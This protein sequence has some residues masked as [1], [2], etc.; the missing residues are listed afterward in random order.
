MTV[1]SQSTLDAVRA[2]PSDTA[3]SPANETRSPSEG[4][5]PA[6]RSSGSATELSEGMSIGRYTVLSRLGVG[7]MGVVV[8]AYDPELDRKVALKLL[9]SYGDDRAAAQGRL[10]REAQALARLSHPNVVAV[11]DVGVHEG[12]VFLAMEFIAGQTLGRWMTHGPAGDPRPWPEVLRVFEAAG[13]GLAAAHDVGLVHRDF[14]PENVMLGD[15]GR[16]CVMDFG[17]AQV[18]SDE[19]SARVDLGE[20]DTET[21]DLLGTSL[22]R[23]GAVLGTPAY[24]SPEQFACTG[25]TARS[26]QFAYCVALYEALYGTRPFSGDTLAQLAYAVTKGSIEGPPPGSTVPPWLREIVVRGLSVAPGDRYLDMSRLLK[27]LG[28]GELRRR[29]SRVFHAVGGLAVLA[30]SGAGYQHYEQVR[31]DQVCA[32]AGDVIEQS[33][34]ASTREAV[35]TGLLATGISYAPVMADQVVSRVDEYVEAWR[36][37]A[38]AACVSATIHGSWTAP[39]Y[40]RAQWCLEERRSQLDALVGELVEADDQVVQEAVSAVADLVPLAACGDEVALIRMVEPPAAGV[41]PLVASILEEVSRAWSL[42]STEKLAEG[43]HVARSARMRAESLSWPPLTA[44]ARAIE[45]SLLSEAGDYAEAEAV[46][47]EAYVQAVRAGA[48]DVAAAV[49]N[50]LVTVVGYRQA[51]HAEGKTWA[52][53]AAVAIEHAGDPL[54]LQEA[55]RSSNLGNVHVSMGEYEQAKALFEQA[56]AVQQEVLGAEHPEVADS[57][58]NL[59]VVHAALGEYEESK[60]VGLRVLKFWQDVQGQEHPRVA[61][62]LTNLGM[63]YEFLGDYEQ[64]RR[65]NMQALAIREQTLGPEHPKVADS[66]NNLGI[67]YSSLGDHE[68]AKVM[69]S[70]ALAIRRR[71]LGPDH[72]KVADSLINLGAVHEAVGEYEQAKAMFARGLDIREQALAPQHPQV[73]D[74]LYNMGYMHA[75]LGEYAQAEAMH[76]RALTIRQRALGPEHP[77]VAESLSD[78][79]DTLVMLGQHEEGLGHLERAVVV[80]ATR[81]V[82]PALLASS[83]FALARALWRVPRSKGRDRAR[84]CALAKQAHEALVADD[85]VQDSVRARLEQWLAGRSGAGRCAASS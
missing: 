37:H 43:L 77:R 3:T 6:Y 38:T 69:H 76:T 62:S 80:L 56:L 42:L 10:Q 46:G 70:R 48:W 7:A 47:T 11:H 40:R 57:L 78:L 67:V 17:L 82:A 63:I 4:S 30:A 36:G 61:D 44:R 50:E 9:K 66:L 25:I 75:L 2:V 81:D 54:G 74:S 68:E 35:Q 26:D 49:A 65:S 41:R 79:G 33:W 60:R 39:T 34:G 72:P 45:A 51:R 5:A 13:R 52:R 59:G 85:A 12:R 29:R 1:G 73:A 22:T 15:D 71:V 83:R 58:N 31:R 53:H 64:V 24:M 84:A 32:T 16:V 20:L 18:A 21:H 27:A 55:A 8:A 19:T 28:S 23:T 14:K